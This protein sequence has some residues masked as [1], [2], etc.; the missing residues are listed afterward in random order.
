MELFCENS[1]QLAAIYYFCKNAPPHV[2]V[3]LGSKYS[4]GSLEEPCKMVLLN[5][6]FDIWGM[7]SHVHASAHAW[8]I[9][10]VQKKAHLVWLRKL[11]DV[12]QIVRLKQ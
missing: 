2:D 4:S 10:D 5:T 11:Q 8:N 1:W 9:G 7:W 3:W 12:Q 6:G